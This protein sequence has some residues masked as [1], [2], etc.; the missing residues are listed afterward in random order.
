MSDKKETPKEESAKEESGKDE[1][2]G[3][4]AEKSDEDDSDL[5]TSEVG[6]D[7]DLKQVMKDMENSESEP[8]DVPTAA[9]TRARWVEFKILHLSK[10]NFFP[11]KSYS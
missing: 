3:S 6:S 5:H 4:A 9:D 1:H 11:A 7:P 2:E 8:E 10:Q